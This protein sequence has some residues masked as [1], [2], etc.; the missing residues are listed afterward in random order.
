MLD[1]RAL[2]LI[3]MIFGFRSAIPFK[4]RCFNNFGSA[5]FLDASLRNARFFEVLI[6]IWLILYMAMDILQLSCIGERK[7]AKSAFAL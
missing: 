7:M 5:I 6:H 3:L 4:Q 2:N 1:R